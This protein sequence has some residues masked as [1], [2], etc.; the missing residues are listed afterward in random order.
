MEASRCAR[1]PASGLPPTADGSTVENEGE[2]TFV[3]STPTFLVAYVNK[4]LGSV[5]RMVRNENRVVFD[6]SG[7]YIEN[8]ILWLREKDGVYVVAMMVAPV[9]REKKG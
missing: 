7:S 2:K 1:C 4:A 6:T 9:G 3:M 8:K 5:S